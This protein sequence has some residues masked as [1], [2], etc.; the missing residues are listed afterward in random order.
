MDSA[1]A[2][3]IDTITGSS[4]KPVHFY[5]TAEIHANG[6]TIPAIKVLSIDNRRDY[7]AKYA[8]EAVVQLVL[9]GGAYAY[10][11]VPFL[12]ELEV[13]LYRTPLHE[14]SG[15]VAEGQARVVERFTAT[16]LDVVVPQVN[17]NGINQPDEYA[18]DLTNLLTLNFQ[19]TNKAVEQMRMRS[20]G[21]IFRKTTTE[22]VIRHLLTEESSR[23]EITDGLPAGVNMIPATNQHV[24]EHIV[25]PHGL[26][27]VDFPAYVHSRCGGVYATGMAY[28]YQAPYWY[29]FPPYDSSGFEKAR[30]TLT[31]I[32]VPSS[33]LPGIERTYRQDGNNLVILAT[34]EVRTTA[35]SEG[36]ILNK[37]NGTRFADAGQ[38]MEGFVTTGGNKALASRG[39]TNNE[40][41][42]T[43]R[44][45]KNNNVVMSPKRITANPYAE[46]SRLSARDG[47]LVDLSWENSD[48]SLIHPG[49][50]VKM[51]YLDGE[52]IREVYGLVIQAHHYT[53]TAGQGV[54]ATRHFSTTNM[55]IFCKRV[56]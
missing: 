50:P 29:V 14:A 51:L 36:E 35:N 40:F 41:V 13:T 8:D 39:A 26:R 32:R 47:D 1:L 3:E 22:A 37:G 53:Q 28:Y 23:I 12:A 27:L 49:M 24:R 7:E 11:V 21:G 6:Q 15:V 42:S 48:P 17:A 4:A 5:W 56:T 10:R 54:T 38:F 9:G 25:L 20:V 31:V 34:G 16:L 18:L 55:R 19:L 43:Q 46:Y 2:R 44:P 33:R 45:T 30:K 52:T